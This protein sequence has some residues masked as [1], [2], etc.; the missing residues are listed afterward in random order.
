MSLSLFELSLLSQS[1]RQHKSKPLSLQS[2]Q[3]SSF[4]QQFVHEP[5]SLHGAYLRRDQVG[6]GK[7]VKGHIQGQLIARSLTLRP[8]W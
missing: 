8:P 7:G 6:G 3:R 5:R 2:E 1:A 4:L